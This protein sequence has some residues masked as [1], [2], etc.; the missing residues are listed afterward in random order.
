[1]AD[2]DRGELRD[3]HGEGRQVGEIRYT[4]G[5]E[6]LDLKDA[7]RPLDELA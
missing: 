5:F 4:E 3:R 2:A 1:V 6:T 7:K